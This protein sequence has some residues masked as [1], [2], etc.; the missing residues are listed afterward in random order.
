[1]KWLLAGALLLLP[2]AAHAQAVRVACVGE[3]STDSAR[4]ENSEEYPAR[5]QALLGAGYEVKEFGIATGALTPSQTGTSVYGSSAEFAE[6]LAFDPDIVLVGPWGRGDV[7]GTTHVG[8][9]EGNVALYD[10]PTALT[11]EVFE[12]ALSDLVDAYV[13][14]PSQPLVLVVLPLP[15]P[16]G[17]D[18]GHITNLVLP[19]TESVATAHGLATL[20]LYTPFLELKSEFDDADHLHPDTGM[21]RMAELIFAALSEPEPEPSVDAGVP[22]SGPIAQ[23]GSASLDGGSDAASDAGISSAGSQFASDAG[24]D[25]APPMGEP[26]KRSQRSA[27]SCSVSAPGRDVTWAGALMLLLGLCVRPR[28]LGCATCPN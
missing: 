8:D 18:S 12:S 5:L 15:F 28:K 26:A 11:S 23:G 27:A 22:D 7:I 19:V 3:H 9:A 6:S 13:E 25:A 4:V 20:D 16:Y 24:D 1:L 21:Q 10:E 17:A 14:L 2:A